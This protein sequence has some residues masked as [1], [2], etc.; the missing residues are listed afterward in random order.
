MLHVFPHFLFM[1]LNNVTPHDVTFLDD[2]TFD[3]VNLIMSSLMM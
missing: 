1:T 2:I 3:D